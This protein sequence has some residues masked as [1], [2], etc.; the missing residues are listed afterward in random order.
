MNMPGFTANRSGLVS[1]A[2]EPG[3][4]GNVPAGYGRDC[5]QVPYTVCVGNRC[6]TEYAWVC[7]YY[8]LPAR[9]A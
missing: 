5:Q 7:T 2:E 8:P 3:G 6:W 4:P 1:P 9:A